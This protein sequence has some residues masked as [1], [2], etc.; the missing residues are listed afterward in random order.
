MGVANLQA[1]NNVL[2]K[3]QE[4]SDAAAVCQHQTIIAG[5]KCVYMV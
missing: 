3:V 2:E 1:H 4:W 5:D